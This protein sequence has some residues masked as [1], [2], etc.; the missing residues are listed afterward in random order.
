MKVP[1]SEKLPSGSYRIRLR[2]GGESI[3][4]TKPTE[5]KAIREA[6]KIKADYRNGI[7]TRPTGGA[8]PLSVAIDDYIAN[9]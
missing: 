2:L 5:R 7:K 6:E 9:R 3:S 8:M 1:K 4:I